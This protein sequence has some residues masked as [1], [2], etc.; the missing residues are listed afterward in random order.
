MGKSSPQLL[1]GAFSLRR[2]SRARVN[3]S[4]T[5]SMNGQEAPFDCPLKQVFGCGAARLLCSTHA[6]THNLRYGN[7]L[8][9][10]V[11]QDPLKRLLVERGVGIIAVSSASYTSQL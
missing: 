11:A 10:Q 7:D 4:R 5:V 2:A 6:G 1:L 3:G 8:G 9:L